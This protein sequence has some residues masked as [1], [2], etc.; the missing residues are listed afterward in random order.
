[1]KELTKGEEQVIK[2]LWGIKKGFLKD[3]VEAFPEPKAANTTI[4]TVLKVLVKKGFV[5]FHTFGKSNEYFP[6]IT[7]DEYTKSHFKIMVQGYF[8]NSYKAFAS[9]FTKEVTTDLDELEEMKALLEEQIEAI[10]KKK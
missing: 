5:G 3:V 6:I 4:A 8:N 10:K 1:M 2:V 9:F 7:Q